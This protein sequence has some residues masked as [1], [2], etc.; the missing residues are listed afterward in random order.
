[1]LSR[2]ASHVIIP[3]SLACDDTGTTWS[4]WDGGLNHAFSIDDLPRIGYGSLLVRVDLLI[5]MLVGEI[6]VVGRNCWVI[7]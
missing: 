3:Y 5:L 6:K 1:L 4:L 2:I 7:D